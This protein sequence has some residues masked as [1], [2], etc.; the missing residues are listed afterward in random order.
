MVGFSRYD[1]KG[2]SEWEWLAFDGI[3]AAV[4]MDATFGKVERMTEVVAVRMCAEAGY[5][6]VCSVLDGLVDN[7]EFAA[8]FEQ[9]DFGAGVESIGIATTV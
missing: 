8:R 7:R 3:V 1:G 4:D 9:E 5:H 2:R 6:L